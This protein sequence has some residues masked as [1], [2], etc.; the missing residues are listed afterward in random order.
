VEYQIYGLIPGP[1]ALVARAVPE[2]GY[3]VSATVGGR[4]TVDGGFTVGPDAV[5]LDAEVVI[6]FDSGTVEGMVEADS[7]LPL[8]GVSVY[9]LPDNPVL[10]WSVTNN[11]VDQAGAF[12]VK[13]GPGRYTVYALPDVAVWNLADPEDLVRLATYRSSIEVRANQT[14]MLK[15]MLAPIWAW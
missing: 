9:L 1:Y 12:S 7:D 4:P 8:E 2:G 15:V 11:R 5:S 10:P 6:A 13:A 3:V 14:V